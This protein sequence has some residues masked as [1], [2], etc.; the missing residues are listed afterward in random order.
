MRFS[1]GIAPC[2]LFARASREWRHLCHTNLRVRVLV[3][4]AS[5]REMPALEFT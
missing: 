5:E 1:S 4:P 3:P 2:F